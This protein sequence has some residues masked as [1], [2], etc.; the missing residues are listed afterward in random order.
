MNQRTNFNDKKSLQ[1]P[2]WTST[3][4]T[5]GLHAYRHLHIGRQGQ[6][7]IKNHFNKEKRK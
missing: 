2:A 7:I 3:P 6:A 1:R 4:E 5:G